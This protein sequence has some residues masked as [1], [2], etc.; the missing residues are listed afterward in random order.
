[1]SKKRENEEVYSSNETEKRRDEVI[2]RMAKYLA[3]AES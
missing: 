3:V 1:M 2:C